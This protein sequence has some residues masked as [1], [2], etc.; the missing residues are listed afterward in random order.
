MRKN[1]SLTLLLF[2]SICCIS[3]LKAQ[4]NYRFTALQ[5]T[6]TTLTGATNVTLIGNTNDGYNGFI[7]LGFNFYYNGAATPTTSVGVST[8]GF[9]TLSGFL[10]NSTPVNNLNSGLAGRRP[11]IAPLWDDISATSGLSYQTSGSA[12]NRVF[13]MQWRNIHW[14]QA[15]VPIAGS[16]QV[17]LYET[18]NFIDFIYDSTG[19][20]QNASASIGLTASGTG[21]GNFASLENTTTTPTVSTTA[22]VTTL[23][24]MMAGGQI[25]RWSYAP[26]ATG[27]T[28][29]CIGQPITLDATG[30]TG[31][32]FTWTG[33]N[34][35]PTTGPTLN[36]ASAT[37]A[38]G[39]TYYVT[40]TINGIESAADSIIVVVGLPQ[41]APVGS[42][43][44]PV[45]SGQ[46]L[47]LTVTNFSP[48][49]TYS[50]TG[51]NAYYSPIAN[52]DINN[53]AVTDAGDYI[54]TA[55]A[56][57]GCSES[58]TVHVDVIQT[59]TA[60]IDVSVSPN[61]T[62]CVGDD[63]EF[64]AA[65][66]YGGTNPQYQ[67]VK[68]GYWVLGA[69]D[70]FW[71]STSLVTFDTIYCILTSNQACVYN[72]VD[73]SNKI[74]MSLAS[75]LAPSV[76]LTAS[77]NQVL[78]GQP[79]DFTATAINAGTNPTYEW[80]RDGVIIPNVTGTTYTGYNLTTN[81]QIKVIVHSSF[82]CALTDT[83]SAFWGNPNIVIPTNVVSANNGNDI[84]LYP[85]P[86]NGNFTISGD[87]KGIAN[88]SVV[89]TEVIN[90]VGQL[91]YN[92]KTE[93][94]NGKFTKEVSLD[95]NLT[96][97]IYVLRVSA[98]N[99][100]NILRFVINK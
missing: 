34:I 62:I 79:I 43:N 94:S 87:A 68:N 40:Q 86:N 65:I 11:V 41:G 28:I 90:M 8:N 63:A 99:V 47:S 61:D 95:N 51:P 12:P 81:D 76:T 55:L 58:D 37:V 85:N 6:Y 97:G 73:T 82:T 22:E 52:S 5:G 64:T 30:I 67:W 84:T 2:L 24:T 50:W 13:T 35:A 23:S 59:D 15:Y 36:I 77:V 29:V 21:A 39:G 75:Y 38:D 3:S 27:T 72:P 89:K 48:A 26:A 96:A 25:Y 19:S 46:T 78:P 53:V 74:V 44:T 14:N 93:I 69:T 7:P 10:N 56:F 83:A 17:K 80:Y 33:P 9:M 45:C 18:S 16:F 98:G 92:G 88:G 31:A 57:N 70:S 20:T 49:F 42:A 54:V 4:V 71:G 1:Y 91:V 60:T 32:I 66:T 100:K